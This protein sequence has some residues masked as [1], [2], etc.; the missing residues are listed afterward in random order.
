MSLQMA[1]S[2]LH[3]VENV[4]EKDVQCILQVGWRPR[5]GRRGRE[6]RRGLKRIRLYYVGVPTPRTEWNHCV[7]QTWSIYIYTEIESC[8]TLQEPQEFCFE[9]PQLLDPCFSNLEKFLSLILLSTQL[10]TI[11][12]QSQ[13]EEATKGRSNYL[14]STLL[15]SLEMADRRES[16]KYFPGRDMPP[17]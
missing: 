6:E 14:G 8:E 1:S 17:R 5:D 11:T 3:S 2:T 7:L 9:S 16:R 4:L 13:A 12:S 10:D 15:L